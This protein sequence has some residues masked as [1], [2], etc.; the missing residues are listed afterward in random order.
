MDSEEQTRRADTQGRTEGL[1]PWGAWEP[2]EPTWPQQLVLPMLLALGWLLF[3]LTANA[4]LALFIACL[5]FGWQDFRTAIWLR[6]TDPHPR[7]AKAGFWFYLSS[8]IWKTAIVPVLAV[9]VIGILWAM[10]ASAHEDPNEVLVRQMA[11]ALAVGMG[12]SGILVI[13]VGVA[14]AFSLSGSL[15]MWIH[16]DL[17]RSRR[18]NLWPPEWPHPLW[19]HDNRGRAILATA[20]IV[21]T[22][23]LPLLLFPLAVMLAPGAEIAV[24]LGIVFG[25]PITSTF[26]YAALRDKVFASSPEECWP[27]SV[28]LSP[29]LAAQRILSEEISG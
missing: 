6:R 11:F 18:E 23:T 1:Q 10:F 7:R 15:R 25:V 17:H 12:A 26:L 16:H 3:E 20:L 21:L 28:V 27:E 4:T 24:V 22:V 13:V 2:T 8:G 14:V 29:E 9:F 5:R 19:R